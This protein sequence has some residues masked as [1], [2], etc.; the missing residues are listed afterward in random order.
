LKGYYP[1]SLRDTRYPESERKRL[2]LGGTPMEKA[3]ISAT[4]DSWIA[5]DELPASACLTPVRDSARYF[6]PCEN[7]DE[8]ERQAYHDFREWFMNRDFQPI[9]DIPVENDDFWLPYEDD[10]SNSFPFSSM[11]FR[12]RLPKFDK[13]SYRL[14]KIYA[15]LKDLAQTHSCISHKE[16]R[17][18]TKRR[19]DAIIQD[20]FGD[21]L[22]V[23]IDHLKKY[24]QYVDKTEG[25]KRIMKLRMQIE[26]SKKIWHKN[27]YDDAGGA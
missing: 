9:L 23:V 25:A 22:N 8:D 4:V 14:Q 15:R 10:D 11:N 21:E 19:F 27:A 24:P 18:N 7:E 20:E 13:A 12:E 1:L 3:Y 6:D 16:G 17:D 5:D 26:K 2:T